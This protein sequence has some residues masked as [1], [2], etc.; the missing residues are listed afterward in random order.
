MNISRISRTGWLAAIALLLALAVARVEA[1]APFGVRNI[2]LVHGAFADGSGW[3]RVIPLLQHK[4]YH[5]TAVQLPLTGLADDVTANRAPVCLS[6][7][8][9]RPLWGAE[10]NVSSWLR[11]RGRSQLR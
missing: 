9:D 1:A 2:V 10:M 7:N 6:C 5:V 3:S 11:A 8:S 4:G